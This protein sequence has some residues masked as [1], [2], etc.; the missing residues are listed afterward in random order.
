MALP[1]PYPPNKVDYVDWDTVIDAIERVRARLGFYP[2]NEELPPSAFYYR[3]GPHG[4][5][6][7]EGSGADEYIVIDV[8]ANEAANTMFS[9]FGICRRFSRGCLIEW[10]AKISGTGSKKQYWPGGLELRHGRWDEGLI[11]FQVDESTYYA[12]TTTGGNNKKT[13][14]TGQDW[15]SDTTLKILWDLDSGYSRAR[16]YVNDVLKATH[17]GASGYVPDD[18]MS[19]FV[20]AGHLDTAPAT[21]TKCYY[22]WRSFNYGEL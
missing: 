17:E 13:Q 6:Y 1:K 11:A 12:V 4:L 2:G 19:F 22:K 18:P 3:V 15:T 10:V 5:I 20:E 14:I 8:H 9:I 16:F 21:A 7:R